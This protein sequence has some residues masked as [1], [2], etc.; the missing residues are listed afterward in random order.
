MKVRNMLSIKYKLSFT[1]QLT[2]YILLV[3]GDEVLLKDES[4]DRGAHSDRS[5]LWFGPRL[6]KRSSPTEDERDLLQRLLEAASNLKYESDLYERQRE[7]DSKAEARRTWLRK[8][9]PGFFTP[10][11]GRSQKERQEPRRRY[12]NNVDFTPRLGRGLDEDMTNEELARYYA[13]R[14]N[15]NPDFTPRL[16]RQLAGYPDSVRVARSVNRTKS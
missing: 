10:R 4:I 9:P 15:I 13:I 2:L 5:G 8:I 7:T 11:P 3:V 16:G 1:F 6:G 14:A 12:N